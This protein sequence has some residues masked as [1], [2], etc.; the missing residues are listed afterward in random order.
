MK[1]TRVEFSAPKPVYLKEESDF[2]NFE[3]QLKPLAEKCLSENWVWTFKVGG[4]VHKGFETTDPESEI[5][6]IIKRDKEKR[7]KEKEVVVHLGGEE[8]GGK[9]QDKEEKVVQVKIEPG[10]EHDGPC[11]SSSSQYFTYHGHD[12]CCDG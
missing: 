10:I 9:G 7:E 8:E 11:P 12:R 5:L 6:R 2:K 1:V 4:K 3:E